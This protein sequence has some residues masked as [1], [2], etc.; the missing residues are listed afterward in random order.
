MVKAVL[1]D[2]EKNGVFEAFDMRKNRCAQ[3]IRFCQVILLVAM[4]VFCASA[5]AE[6]RLSQ[7]FSDALAR[8]GDSKAAHAPTATA[9]DCGERKAYLATG[10]ANSSDADSILRKAGASAV[11]MVILGENHRNRPIDLYV[12]SLEMLK[13]VDPALDCLFLEMYG[14]E[15]PLID[16]YISSR[17]TFEQTRAAVRKNEEKGRSSSFRGDEQPLF[18]AAKRLGL[19]VI[20]ADVNVHT[21]AQMD[22]DPSLIVK[23]IKIRNPFMADRIADAFSGGR[24]HKGA[25]ILGKSHVM[26][27]VTD[28]SE[29]GRWPSVLELVRTHGLKTFAI[30]VIHRKGIEPK[31]GDALA[32]KSCS[33][34]LWERLPAGSAPRGFTPSSP[35]PAIE[36]IFNAHDASFSWDG[37]PLWE[38]YD[39]VILKP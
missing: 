20:A 12:S 28:R 29:R 24:C 1:G 32:P 38:Q 18:D 6:D 39:G 36:P 33:W 4:I 19:R 13:S 7:G 15:Q 3:M 21:P 8:L 9:S 35:S 5:R 16:D 30:D 27:L 26:P 25:M 22:K 17:T 23:S 37:A 34:N 10:L 2:M 31:Y 14:M 11:R